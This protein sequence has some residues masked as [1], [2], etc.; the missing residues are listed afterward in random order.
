MGSSRAV[1]LEDVGGVGAVG[2]LDADVV[3]ADG[4]GPVGYAVCV[5]LA[6]RDAH[7]G[8]VLLMGSDAGSAATLGGD[9]GNDGSRGGEEGSDKADH[10]DGVEEKV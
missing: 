8:G 10:C 5:D 1:N 6:A 3:A 4:T 9:G 2:E 7:G